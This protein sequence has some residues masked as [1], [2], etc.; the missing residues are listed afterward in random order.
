MASM[1]LEKPHR[2]AASLEAAGAAGSKYCE[3]DK[4]SA[5]EKVVVHDQAHDAQ[6]SKH[7]QLIKHAHESVLTQ[8]AKVGAADEKKKKKEKEK[9]KEKKKAASTKPTAKANHKIVEEKKEK[10][11]KNKHKDDS[12]SSNNDSDGHDNKK[13]LEGKKFNDLF[14]DGYRVVEYGNVLGNSTFDQP[15][16]CRHLDNFPIPFVCN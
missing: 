2:E 6:E 1:Q 10:K 13:K 9:E 7:G 11:K 3:V 14:G 5:A 8:H 4:A 15:L 16:A 12:S